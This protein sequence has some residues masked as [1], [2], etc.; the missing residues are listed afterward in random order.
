MIKIS[1]TELSPVRKIDGGAGPVV[2]FGTPI[3][4]GDDVT[5]VG[6]TYLIDNNIFN[7]ICKNS[8]PDT[9]VKFISYASRFGLELNPAFAISE[10]FRTAKD[11]GG[12]LRYYQKHLQNNF[13]IKITDNI[14]NNY[15]SLVLRNKPIFTENIHQI[16]CFM[17]IIKEIYNSHLSENDMVDVFL[18]K[19]FDK[20]LPYLIYPIYAGLIFFFVKQNIHNQISI[21][22]K[23]DSF[24]SLKENY[25]SEKKSLHN[26]STDISI[27]LDCRELYTHSYSNYPSVYSIVTCDEVVGYLLNNLC[28]HSVTCPNNGRYSSQ[29]AIRDSSEWKDR[30]N[31]YETQIKETFNRRNIG[32]DKDILNR[33]KNLKNE[34]MLAINRYVRLTSR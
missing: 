2:Y 18:K 3:H 10:L 21:R 1:D 26:I 19:I 7:F 22:K 4:G 25:D 12:Y 20:D 8:I 30:F 6:A 9:F 31:S 24:L 32:T 28:V 23:I 13:N 11:P 14:L 5:K 15:T 34:G 16:E 33:S 17:A 29:V 27:F